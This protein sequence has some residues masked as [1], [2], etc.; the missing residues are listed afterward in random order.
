M[1]CAWDTMTAV[2]GLLMS[3]K[4]GTAVLARKQSSGF[5]DGMPGV[6]ERVMSMVSVFVYA[7]VL[8]HARKLTREGILLC[9]EG[10]QDDLRRDMFMV[11]KVQLNVCTHTHAH[12]HTCMHA[13]TQRREQD[14]MQVFRYASWRTLSDSFAHTHTDEYMC[15]HTHADVLWTRAPNSIFHIQT[16]INTCISA[17]IQL[18]WNALPREPVLRTCTTQ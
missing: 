10:M 13:N 11:K 5:M 3:Q 15:M 4:Q 1:Q 9:S 18:C 14:N 12:T 7:C 6:L 17:Q 8:C 16:H 2:S